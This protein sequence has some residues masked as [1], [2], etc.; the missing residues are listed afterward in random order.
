[1]RDIVFLVNETPVYNPRSCSFQSSEYCAYSADVVC[2]IFLFL[3]SA[4]CNT[5]LKIGSPRYC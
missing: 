2:N 1:M 4:Q 5:F 3:K